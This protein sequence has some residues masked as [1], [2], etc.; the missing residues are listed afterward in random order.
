MKIALGADSVGKSL[1][2]IDVLD[3]NPRDI[4]KAKE[5]LARP[6]AARSRCA[7]GG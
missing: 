5:R 1:L 2:D 6:P 3:D 4:A 7:N